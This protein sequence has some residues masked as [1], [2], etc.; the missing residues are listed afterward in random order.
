MPHPDAIRAALAAT[1]A[2]V[3]QTFYDLGVCGPARTDQAANRN[4]CGMFKT[5][6]LRNVATRK[7]FMHNG[8]FT[9]LAD[10]VR[11]Y[12]GRDTQSAKWYPRKANGATD[13]YNDLPV[14]MRGNIDVIDAPLDRS[15]G[16]R[17]ALSEAEVQ[18]IVAFLRTL[19]DAD[20]M[21]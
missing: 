9:D 18:D 6:T 4:Y 10:A 17:P 16:E 5:P 15:A 7:A 14:E 3:L 19:T 13:R 11:F 12:A 21:N 8:V 2:N 20:V 1:Q